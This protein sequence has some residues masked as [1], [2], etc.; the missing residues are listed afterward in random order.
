MP[1]IAVDGMRFHVSDHGAGAP[2]VLLHGFTG[3]GAS[4]WPVRDRLARDWRV[5]AVDLIGHGRSAAPRDPARYAYTRALDDLDEI[6]AALGF[7]RATWLGY[8]LGGRLALG[9]AVRHPERVAAL[10]L[11]SANPGIAAAAEREERRRTDAALASRIEAAGIASFVAEWE[12]LP[13]W[14]SQRDLPDAARER[15]R[16]IRLGNQ[17]HALANSLRGMGQGSQQNLWDD[18]GEIRVPTLVIA[19]ER[20]AKFARIA[21]KMAAVIPGATLAIVPGAGH[22][23]HLER[24][25]VYLDLVDR[26][27]RRGEFP[28]PL[29]HEE[30]DA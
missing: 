23:V 2:L 1:E 3:S 8:S 12:R 16:A 28:V 29:V 10:I 20:D 22:A 25:E 15:Q 24:P 5:L 27:L 4:W 19:G 26:F 13:L 17:P 9:F 18:L 11:E 6:A 14:E 21:E 30:H 7:T